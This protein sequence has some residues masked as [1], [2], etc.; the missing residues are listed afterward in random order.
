M[1]KASEV[2]RTADVQLVEKRKELMQ[3]IERGIQNAANEGYYYY[4]I[5]EPMLTAA[6]W[7]MIDDELSNA[8]FEVRHNLGILTIMWSEDDDNE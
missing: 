4:S 8:G 3:V 7:K 5:Q 2:R 1:I 6:A